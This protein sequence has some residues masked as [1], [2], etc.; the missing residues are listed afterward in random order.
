MQS[1]SRDSGRRDLFCTNL[2]AC[3]CLGASDRSR[4]RGR[5]PS[6]GRARNARADLSNS[7]RSSGPLHNVERPIPRRHMVDA[8]SIL[9]ASNNDRVPDT[10]S[11]QSTCTPDRGVPGARR[12]VAAGAVRRSGFRRRPG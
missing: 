9:R 11:R 4:D 5:G 2:C 1:F 7:H 8:S 12:S 6:D 10:S 3:R